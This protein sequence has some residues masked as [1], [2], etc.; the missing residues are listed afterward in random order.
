M[1]ELVSLLIA[2]Y[3]RADYLLEAIQSAQKQTW[4]E[5]EMIVIDD[6]STDHT[7]QILEEM[8]GKEPR[9]KVFRQEN[10]GIAAAENRG[11]KEAKGKFVAI[12]DS[13]DLI[14]PDKIENQL[15]F[16][17]EHPQVDI[18]HT[19][20]TLIDKEGAPLFIVEGSDEAQENFLPKMLFRNIMANPNTILGRTNQL[21]NVPY[22]EKYKYCCDYD[23]ILRLAEHFSFGYLN[24]PLTR[25]RRHE[26]NL[27]NALDLYLKDQ[28]QILRE[29]TPQKIDAIVQKA[30]MT[31]D[32]KTLLK[33]KI[34]YNR[35]EFAKASEYLKQARLQQSDFYLG[36]IAY[37]L[38][39][40]KQAALFYQKCL[41]K[42]PSDAACLNNL[43]CTFA[44]LD[45]R[46]EA[47]KCFEKALFLRDNYLDAKYNLSN[48]M[49]RLT[50][51]ELRKNLILY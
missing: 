32:E 28:V 21:K 16:L 46:V 50:D 37:K 3:N 22:Q 47:T 13:D 7:P 34:F 51:K 8:R 45:K 27:T 20:V 9:L 35:N 11:L 33:G 15:N 40:F 48:K 10:R 36:N 23:R 30:Q 2:T 1:K 4:Q 14:E 6:G 25:W 24:L 29:Y 41:E 5:L 38:N 17:K 19:A 43:G 31:K 44:K 26:G 42:D 18:V 39:N 12:L 49:C